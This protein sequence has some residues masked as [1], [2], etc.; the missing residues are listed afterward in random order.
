MAGHRELL[1]AVEDAGHHRAHADEDRADQHDPRH[2]DRE[3]GG[4]RIEAGR[5]DRHE[6]G[7]EDGHQ[8]AQAGERD[9]HEVDD[10]AGQPPRLR[11]LRRAPGSC[12]KTGMS[13]AL[14]RAGHHEL[15]DRVGDAEG[16]EVGVELA[17]GAE[18]ASR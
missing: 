10:A 18:L 1:V 2:A 9:E 16:G 17:A 4:R 13:A 3:L 7:G 15:E 12:E 6:D 8:Q 5:H 14:Q 11:V